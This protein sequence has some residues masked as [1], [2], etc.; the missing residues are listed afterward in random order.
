MRTIHRWVSI[1]AALFLGL[2]AITGVYLQSDILL[3]HY[4][5]AQDS[6]T[7][8]LSMDD[9][10]RLLAN[11]LARMRD[12]ATGTRIASMELS[13]RGGVPH[14]DVLFA[15]PGGHM[16]TFDARSSDLSTQK[17]GDPTHASQPLRLRLRSLAINLHQGGIIGVSG[18]WLGW[19][20]GLALL[21]LVTT[22]LVVY[23]RIYR[24]RLKLRRPGLFWH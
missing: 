20:C 17:S 8:T 3:E 24:Q 4:F 16:Q 11:S 19:T 22:G 7:Q 5:P 21:T 6:D 10:P 12:A 9:A 23:F 1:P 13:A 2:I 15:G 18:G 14:V